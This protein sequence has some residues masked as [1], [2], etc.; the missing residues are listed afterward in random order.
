M[1]ALLF[2]SLAGAIGTGLR[3]GI[4]RAMGSWMPPAFPWA[5][6]TVNVIGCF[7]LGV[8]TEAIGDR[9]V[10]DVEVRTILGA[11]LMGGFTTYSSFDIEL[12]R[13]GGSGA[14]QVAYGYG[15]ATL[16]VCLVAGALGLALGRTMRTA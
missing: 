14:T 8:I 6:F 15:A 16:G 2:V 4:A 12:L 13:L 7:L 3:F 11:G 1:R 5:T 9:R 10:A